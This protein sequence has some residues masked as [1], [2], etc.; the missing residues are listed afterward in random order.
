MTNIVGVAVDAYG[1]CAHYHSDRD[2]IA[3]KCATC[4]RYW[5]CYQC[6]DALADHPFGRMPLTE[7]AVL[8][9]ACGT[10]MTY[11]Q[12]RRWITAQAAATNSILDARRIDTNI[13]LP[14]IE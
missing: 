13:S 11:W 10:A 4:R 8:C 6:H 2:I 7:P 5:A 3:N 12:Y 14:L 1:R 9:G